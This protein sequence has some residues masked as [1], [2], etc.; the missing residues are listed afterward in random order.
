MMHSGAPAVTGMGLCTGRWLLGPLLQRC[1]GSS[2]LRKEQQRGQSQNTCCALRTL[3]DHHWL[4]LLWLRADNKL[5]AQEWEVLMISPLQK[6]EAI[7]FKSRESEVRHQRVR[8]APNG[9]FPHRWGTAR[10]QGRFRGLTTRC[11]QAFPKRIPKKT[12]P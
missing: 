5:V 12:R 1:P 10:K 9:T 6:D 11:W 3:G 2:D 7:V 4:F 8:Q